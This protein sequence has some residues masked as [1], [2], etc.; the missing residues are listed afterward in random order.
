L[1]QDVGTIKKTLL[2]ATPDTVTTTSPG[3]APT[4]TATTMLVAPQL[5]G[6][7]A[8]PLKVTVLPPCVDPKFVPA[9]VTEVPIA[10]ELGERLEM[11]GG[12][13]GPILQNV[14]GFA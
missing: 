12:L 8:V 11:V 3:V 2:L 7:A 9:I 10:P 4:G 14:D 1:D 13:A 6:V 5:V